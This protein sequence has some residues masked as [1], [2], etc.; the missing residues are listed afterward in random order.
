[1]KRLQLMAGA[2]ARMP[3]KSSGLA[4]ASFRP[5]RPPVEK[6]SQYMYLGALP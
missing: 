3:S 1:M 5:W 4:W 2:P 6:P